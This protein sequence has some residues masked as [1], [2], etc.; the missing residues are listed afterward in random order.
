[1][2]TEIQ[3]LFIPYELSVKIKEFGFNE[4]CLG[5]YIIF[6]KNDIKKTVTFCNLDRDQTGT[7]NLVGIKTGD[8]IAAPTYEQIL[9]WLKTNHNIIVEPFTSFISKEKY[10]TMYRVQKFGKTY[11]DLDA[12]N[13]NKAI[14]IALTLIK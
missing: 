14:E 9:E 11:R 3:K 6:S 10:S 5:Y 4:T 7:K 1:M 8:F 2:N 12:K 13:I